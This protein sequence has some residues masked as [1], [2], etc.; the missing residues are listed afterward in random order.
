MRAST[1]LGV[2]LA[3]LVGACLIAAGGYA[4]GALPGGAEG[5]AAR[6]G[7]A[8]P[9]YWLGLLA[10]VVGLVTLS[11]AWWRLRPVTRSVRWLLVTGALWAAPLLVAPPLASRDVYAYA[12]QGALWLDGADPY[13]QGVA[14]GGC[15]WAAAVPELWRETPTPYGPL[16]V[17]LAGLVVALA[18]AVTDSVD[19][20]LVVAVGLFRL[21]AL[22]GGLLVAGCLPRLARVG[23]VDPAVATWLGLLSP[24]V[25][26]HLVAGAHNDGLMVGLV[27]AA[28][29]LAAGVVTRPAAAGRPL[30]EAG[31]PLTGVDVPL[32]GAGVLLALAV[33]VK[34]TAL[35][36]V[37]FVVL[38]GAVG[39]R[40]AGAVGRRSA[41]AVA[42]TAVPVLAAGLLA[43]TGLSLL[44]GLDLGWLAALSGTGRLV[45]WTSLPTGLGM[46]A[47]Y[48]LRIVG[49]P[50][51]MA[52]AVAVA[53]GIGL[54]VLVAVAV[55]LLVRA[56]LAA[57]GPAGSAPDTAYRAGAARR[58]VVATCGA[59]FGAL[60]VLSPVFYP[61]YALTAIAVLA[62]GVADRRPGRWLAGA[63]VGLSFLVLPDGLGLAVLTKLPGALLDTALVIG[64]VVW[65]WRRRREPGPAGREASERYTGKV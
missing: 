45:Q 32:T 30:T 20:Q 61:W 53:R 8:G 62:A 42:R 48:L 54:V 6:D 43:F 64:L 47:G 57:V 1:G 36:A 13:A 28:L 15:A 10:C 31:R 5:S 55:A 17:A 16:A 26:V 4:A 63:A 60:A 50:E 58:R 23:G 2:R 12:C 3:G 46:T 39:R 19:G 21:V 59:T 38:L 25:A 24:L 51:G 34:V 52:G 7:T 41:G 9:A 33:A 49:H 65:A 14:T 35:V 44:T 56:G 22:G 18:R 11:V 40:S 37:P 27:L 29:A